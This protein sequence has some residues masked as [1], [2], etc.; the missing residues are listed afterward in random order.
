MSLL[1]EPPFASPERG[2]V[3]FLFGSPLTEYWRITSDVR[4]RPDDGGA[5]KLEAADEG[6]GPAASGVSQKM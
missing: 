5:S 1:W 2:C 6:A 4:L 3:P